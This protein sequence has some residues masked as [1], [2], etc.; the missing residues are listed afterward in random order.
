MAMDGFGLG[1]LDGGWLIVACNDFDFPSKAPLATLAEAGEVVCGA[2]EEHV[3]VSEAAAFAGGVETWRVA[4]DCE[5]G[6]EDLTVTGSPPAE[7]KKL[8]DAALAELR[9]KADA[10]YVFDVPTQLAAT[11]CGFEFGR[12]DGE[13]TALQPTRTLKRPKTAGGERPG[14]FARLFGRR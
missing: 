2:L 1:K 14:F 13:F 9:A 3:M 12:S 5:R 6:Q 11:V 4:H 7:L 10:D 8:L